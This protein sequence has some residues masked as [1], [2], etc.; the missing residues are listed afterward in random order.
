[1]S[2]TSGISGTRLRISLRAIAASLSGT[3]S[4]TISQPAL[5][6]S[7][8]CATVAPTSAVSVLVIDWIATGAPPP[9]CTCLTCTALVVLI[10]NLSSHVQCPTSNVQRPLMKLNLT[11]EQNAYSQ[12][13][14]KP[15]HLG[16]WTLDLI[17]SRAQAQSWPRAGFQWT[18]WKLAS[19]H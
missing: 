19:T 8:I 13:P 18:D 16:N 10:I 3:A 6:I 5:T 7:S 15:L 14:P 9:I 17:T 4:R 11:V 1:M 2:A 12:V